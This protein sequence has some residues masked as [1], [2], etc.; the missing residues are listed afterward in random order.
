MKQL[1]ILFFILTS[2]NVFA[3]KIPWKTDL[4]LSAGTKY[5][6]V[7]DPYN[8]I[9]E[10][11]FFDKQ[12]KL[13]KFISII[14]PVMFSKQ[15]FRS[16]F[17]YEGTF[18]IKRENFYNNK[19]YEIVKY[20]Y[21]EGNLVLE[22]E[23]DAEEA[24]IRR[25][26]SYCYSDGKLSSKL[27][28]ASDGIDVT[29]IN[30]SDNGSVSITKGYYGDD[31]LMDVITEVVDNDTVVWEKHDYWHNN[32]V[33]VDRKKYLYD[34]NKNVLEYCYLYDYGN[35]LYGCYRYNYVNN[36][37]TNG[38]YFNNK[39]EVWMEE[40]YDEKGNVIKEVRPK[41]E[42][43]KEEEVALFKNYYNKRGDLIKVKR[44]K[45]RARIKK[46]KIKYC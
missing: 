17:F 30:Y 32:G 29:E 39:E 6:H 42:W 31:Q 25:Q 15:I 33:L 20:S 14:K 12:G 43:Q 40:F 4:K 1:Y 22:T 2:S 9:D 24:L 45:G 13:E 21:E 34:T 28:V 16:Q 35:G 37:I 5:V 19:L 26:K 11:Y 8:D 36:V 41:V 3:Q 23:I 46:I 18:L 44:N 10:E 7:S 38:K 27:V